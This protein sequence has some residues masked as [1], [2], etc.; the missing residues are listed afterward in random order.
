LNPLDPVKVDPQFYKVAI[1]N[2]QVRVLKVRIGPHE[3]APM[4]A[5]ALN[6]V[7]V[8]LTDINLRVK[9]QGGKEEHVEHKAGEIVW[10]TPT[11]H[12]EENLNGTPVDL[13]AVE[14]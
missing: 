3:T 8:Y 9:T 14:I 5:H 4:H 11:Q 6:R 2:D 1:E 10:G 7:V 13:I 12:F